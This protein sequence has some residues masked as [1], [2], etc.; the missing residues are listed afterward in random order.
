VTAAAVAVVVA[1]AVRMAA[2]RHGPWHTRLAALARDVVSV[3][4]PQKGGPAPTG[5]KAARLVWHDDAW[6]LTGATMGA[7][8]VSPLRGAVAWC[9]AAPHRAPRVFCTCGLHAFRDRADAE[10]AAA[11]GTGTCVVVEVALWGD[12]LEH[13]AGFRASN[14]EALRVRLPAC[15]CGRPCVLLE[16][17]PA[18]DARPVCARCARPPL[19]T[20]PAVEAAEATGVPF[21]VHDGNPVGPLPVEHRIVADA[22]D[23][24]A[25][26][27]ANHAGD[28]HGLHRRRNRM[29]AAAITCGIEGEHH[30]RACLGAISSARLFDH[31]DRASALLHAV[32]LRTRDWLLDLDGA[33]GFAWRRAAGLVIDDIV[34]YGEFARAVYGPAAIEALA[35]WRR[36]PPVPKRE[37]TVAALERV[38]DAAANGRLLVDAAPSGASWE[39]L[40]QLRELQR[41][42]PIG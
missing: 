35:W 4:A 21:V 40:E 20:V 25:G 14:Q 9:T 7:G 5:Y 26:L 39:T 38:M 41:R 3:W 1:A 27:E 16:V 33:R 11:D 22:V 8:V 12:V 42:L 17:A 24:L 2:G 29:A 19:R 32:P 37:M 10:R 34:A 36:L 6:A 18:G 30:L 15:G 28:L 13:S 23:Y 31:R